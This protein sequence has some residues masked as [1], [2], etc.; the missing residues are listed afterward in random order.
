M[1]A[2]DLEYRPLHLHKKSVAP[3]KKCGFFL[4]FDF[5]GH[6]S[7]FLPHCKKREMTKNC[8]II[9]NSDFLRY[10]NQIFCASMPK[11]SITYFHQICSENTFI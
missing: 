7:A 8:D 5:A 6:F 2:W 11:N 10:H 3:Y 9:K 4:V 1:Y